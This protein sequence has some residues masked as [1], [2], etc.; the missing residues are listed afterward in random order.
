MKDKDKDKIYLIASGRWDD[1]SHHAVFTDKET[2]EAVCKHVNE[3]DPPFSDDDEWE[4]ETWAVD[5]ISLDDLKHKKPYQVVINKSGYI[6]TVMAD[7]SFRCILRYS[8]YRHNF[9]CGTATEGIVELDL[10][11]AAYDILDAEARAQAIREEIIAKGEW[12]NESEFLDEEKENK[13]ET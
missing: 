5:T 4:V 11:I 12:P 8:N 10:R 3:K 7:E 9:M 1:Y 2:A 13:D 6:K